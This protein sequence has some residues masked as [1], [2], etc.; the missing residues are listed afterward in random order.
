M[1]K[2]DSNY[3]IGFLQ[4]LDAVMSSYGFEIIPAVSTQG[5]RNLKKI[6]RD[7]ARA[8]DEIVTD[9]RSV[10][11][12]LE[13]P[14]LPHSIRNAEITMGYQSRAH[15]NQSI[16][17]ITRTSTQGQQFCFVT[18]IDR[19][20]RGPRLYVRAEEFIDKVAQNGS[21]LPS[22]VF[23]SFHDCKRAPMTDL[24]KAG[25]ATAKPFTH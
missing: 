13:P 4:L 16:F 25:V 21:V 14:Q 8:M 11:V 9:V 5:N 18:L 23:A 20:N 6:E 22:A 17:F 1:S 10:S 19:V 15:P 12:M 7:V 24:L 3:G 2:P